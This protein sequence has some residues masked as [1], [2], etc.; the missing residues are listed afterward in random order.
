MIQV[1][2][3]HQNLPTSPNFS[4]LRKFK[5]SETQKSEIVSPK[6]GENLL[7]HRE[8]ELRRLRERERE[9]F[10]REDEIKRQED[11]VRSMCE[12]YNTKKS[13]WNLLFC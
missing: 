6:F 7:I 9:N 10:K 8:D 12:S 2:S 1:L 4:D 5:F 3:T 11:Y 13:A